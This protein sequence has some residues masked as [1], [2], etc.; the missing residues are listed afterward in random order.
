MKLLTVSCFLAFL[1]AACGSDVSPSWE[2][3]VSASDLR[4]AADGSSGTNIT[5]GVFNTANSGAP[6]AQAEPVLIRCLNTSNSATG[7]FSGFDVEGEA[8]AFTDSVGLVEFRYICGGDDGEDYAVNCVAL[9][10][11]TSGQLRP[12]IECISAGVT[13]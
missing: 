6:V 5:V 4:I 11:Q 8:T 13:E 12:G 7:W 1:L 9:A 10:K 3:Q 2:L